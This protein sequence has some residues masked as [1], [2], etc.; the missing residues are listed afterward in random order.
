M[1]QILTHREEAAQL[2][3]PNIKESSPGWVE[4]KKANGRSIY[5]SC[6][7]GQQTVMV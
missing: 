4:G 7:V 2:I 6:F 5:A 3:A 1:I